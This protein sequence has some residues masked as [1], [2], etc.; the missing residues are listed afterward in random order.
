MLS[1]KHEWRRAFD[2]VL[3]A[4]CKSNICS[5][6]FSL[7]KGFL[8]LTKSVA[9]PLVVE[10]VETAEVHGLDGAS[11]EDDDDGCDDEGSHL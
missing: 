1:Q 3:A 6:R 11:T 7:N 9:L 8:E 4:I 5:R 10:A 2:N